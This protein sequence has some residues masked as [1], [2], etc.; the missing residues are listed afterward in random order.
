MGGALLRGFVARILV[1][2][3]QASAASAPL[4]GESL[5]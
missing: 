5:K 4:S 2:V 3:N 1:G